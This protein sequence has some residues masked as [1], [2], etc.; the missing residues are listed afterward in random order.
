MTMFKSALVA[1]AFA[2]GTALVAPALAY[3][4]GTVSGGG[5][6]E[7]TIVFNGTPGTRKI[8]PTKDV[9]ICGEPRE[10]ALI[11]VGPDKGV[12]DAVVY[13]VGVNSGK[14]WPPA[15]KKPELNNQKCRFEPSVQVI[16]AGPLDVINRDPV[17]HN[18]HGYYGKR[19]AFNM[20]QPNQNQTIAA[21]LPKAG[22]VKVD[23][24]AHGWMEG[25]IYVVDNPYFALTGADGKFNISEVPPGEYD[26]VAMQS[27]TKPVQQK[28]MVEA[29]K[30]TSLSIELKKK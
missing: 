1:C 2:G 9:E 21:D 19:T 18:T 25:W 22:A 3:E 26:L 14:A 20:A 15:G 13:L 16:P 5:T 7:G 6:I 29:G 30:P 8:V 28:V 4:V 12:K 11:E 10:E 24:D 17:L 23:C 27:A